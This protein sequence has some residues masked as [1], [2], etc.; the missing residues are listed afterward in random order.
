MVS[1]PTRSDI[2]GALARLERDT[3]A[4]APSSS[5][6]GVALFSGTGLPTDPP[7]REKLARWRAGDVDSSDGLGHGYHTQ[8]ALAGALNWGVVNAS[9]C[10]VLESAGFALFEVDSSPSYTVLGV[11]PPASE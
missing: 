2:T 1:R 5:V 4:P 6:S 7:I 9:D 3:P 8:G 11:V 10:S